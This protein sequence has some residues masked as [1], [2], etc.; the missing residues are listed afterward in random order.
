MWNLL[1]RDKG[2]NE[3]VVWKLKLKCQQQTVEHEVY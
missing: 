1:A 2:D 3:A